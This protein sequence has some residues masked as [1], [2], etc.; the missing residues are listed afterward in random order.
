MT[1]R[2]QPATS[3]WRVADSTGNTG[4]RT[5]SPRPPLGVGGGGASGRSGFFLG[6]SFGFSEEFLLHYFVFVFTFVF[7]FG[8]LSRFFCN[9]IGE[10][11]EAALKRCVYVKL[12]R[13]IQK[14]HTT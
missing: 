1:R 13:E 4:N 7:I 10:Q 2:R 11:S 9:A 5:R 14:G 3:R 8:C 6:C 12:R